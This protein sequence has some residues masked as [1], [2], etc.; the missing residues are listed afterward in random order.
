M[1]DI[2]ASDYIAEFLARKHVTHVFELVGGMTTHMLDSLNKRD[3]INIISFHHEQAAA[4]AAE[5]V[6]RITG[7]PGV[8]M[9]TSGPGATNLL[10]AIGSCFFDSAPAVF[11]TGQVN[12]YELKGN[13]EIRQMGF[14][15]TD[16]VE[17]AKPITKSAWQVSSADELPEMLQRAFDIATGG[18]P[19]PVLLDIPMNVQRAMISVA[20]ICE[21]D[22]PDKCCK[23]IDEVLL[24]SLFEQLNLAKRPLVLVG[25]GIRSSLTH[26]ELR[27]FIGRVKVPVV[28]SLMAVDALSGDDPLRIGLIG[29]YGNRWA[30][31]A[32]GKSDFILVLGSRLDVRQTGSN[33]DSFMLDRVIFQVDCD[34][35][36]INNRVLGCV[37]IV[38]Q[39]KDFFYAAS[40]MAENEVFED[41]AGW[42]AEINELKQLYPAQSEQNVPG[43]NPNSFLAE[44]SAVSRQ[45]A[46]YTID[47][48][49]H[50][51]WAAQ[52]IEVCADQYYLTSGGMGSMG[53]ALPV[54]IGATFACGLRPV[55]AIA[56]DGG[57][58]CNIQELQTVAHHN[59]PIKMVVINNNCLGMVKQ[60][61]ESYFDCRYQS[62]VIGY[63][64]PDFV[65]VAEAYGI[66]ALNVDDPAKVEA[67]LNWLWKDPQKP[68]LLQVMIDQSA[69]AY[70]KTAFGS[71]ITEMEPL[72]IS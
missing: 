57:F 50:Q 7:V 72:I 47:V 11:I 29:T 41:R 60:F 64:A 70:P 15:E 37:A 12:T 19:G 4:F 25:G 5:A 55:V 52:S 1:P 62:T 27:S 30:N 53:F 23:A 63:S 49:Q 14:Q 31:L 40:K 34:A 35:G 16:I 22:D 45:A 56:G 66:K 10:T 61:Q 59:L 43:I 33:T 68:A 42:L 48:G 51:M 3:D 13:L 39:L 6:G 28:N 44:L 46:G 20:P 38:A 67:A 9:A 26:A 18:R 54:A 71:P 65:R 21:D 58:Q 8:A 17:L 69:N 32:I 36:E 2:K 24:R